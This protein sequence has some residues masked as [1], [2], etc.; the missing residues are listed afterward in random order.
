MRLLATL[1]PLLPAL[2]VGLFAM[3][4]GSF[5]RG[6]E[7]GWVISGH[8]ALAA[9]VL[10]APPRL[11]QWLD[12]LRLGRVG[13][14]L[15]WLLIAAA[16]VSAGLSPV[17]RAGRVGLTLAPAFLLLPSIVS[18]VWSDRRSIRRGTAALAWVGVALAV[19]G[20]VGRWVGWTVRAAEPL[21]HHNFLAFVLAVS[22][23][24]AAYTLLADSFADPGSESDPGSEAALETGAWKSRWLAGVATGI[25]LAGIWATASLTGVLAVL[26]AVTVL[27]I[28]W[29]GAPGTIRA[30]R[31]L[32]P[33]SV[34]LLALVATAALLV[35]GQR[36]RL[37]A[38]SAGED[39]SSAARAVYLEAGIEGLA[40]NPWLGHGPG[41]TA[42]TL[43]ATLRPVP[44]VNP[45]GEI[46]GDLHLFPLTVA[47]ELG[48]V[49]FGLAVLALVWFVACRLRQLSSA[50]DPALVA[51]GLA[52]LAA[53][54][55]GG[56]GTGDWRI[57]ALPLVVSVAV[58]AVLAGS[59]ARREPSETGGVRGRRIGWIYV[60]LGILLLGGP[61]RA[62]WQYQ[63]ALDRSALE[64]AGAAAVAEALDRAVALDPEFPL[65]RARRAWLDR[66]AS[67]ALRAAEIA[68]GVAPFWLIAGGLAEARSTTGRRALEVACRLAPFDP[69]APYLLAAR[70]PESAAAPGL[71]ARAVFSYPGL[72]A[73]NLW[74]RDDLA[75]LRGATLDFIARSDGVDAGLR[76]AI[77]E[78]AAIASEVVTQA[79]DTVRQ[80]VA[81]GLEI[82]RTGDHDGD[83][84]GGDLSLFAFRRAPWPIDWPLVEID[85][86]RL[87]ALPS[88][89]AASELSSTNRTVFE[90][91]RKCSTQPVENPVQNLPR[92]P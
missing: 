40:R 48:L 4:S 41:S 70:Y 27:A 12:P 24:I 83:R 33:V 51:C 8:L 55:T 25:I 64:D 23:P 20:L 26:V 39:A 50:R 43:A 11:R 17:S 15:P 91:P 49:G 53:A 92:S 62:H 77:L 73:G 68:Q 10:A 58:G 35:V 3:A 82:D 81:L 21:G 45:P 5:G 75:D 38:I 6:V 31:W 89:P 74:Q 34:S 47:Y 80:P 42:W 30:R 13:A 66:D 79:Q 9:V 16:A 65:Y 37:A 14:L 36:S 32:L 88:L 52:S 76:E 29:V 44:G 67:E 86:G 60:A 61:D 56:L 46:V 59:R 63:R 85:P 87:S 22:L 18:R 54:L 84:I 1:L 90:R 78:A 2:L 28:L 72:L 7:P 69:F 19:I 57:V 71:A